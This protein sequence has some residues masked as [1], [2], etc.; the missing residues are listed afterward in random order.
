MGHRCRWP[1]LAVRQEPGIAGLGPTPFSQAWRSFV[2]AGERGSGAA[3]HN[4]DRRVA[5]GAFAPGHIGELTR[6][7]PF[8]LV[9]EVLAQTGA[10]RCSARSGWCRHGARP[11]CR[12]RRLFDGLGYRQVFD[13]LCTGLAGMASVRPSGSALRQARRRLGP[14][15]MTALFDLVSGPAATTAAAAAAA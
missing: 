15:P 11:T 13:R 6:I 10:V 7:V 14:A 8:E 3:V 1:I 2:K 9:D 5:A 4:K 12:W